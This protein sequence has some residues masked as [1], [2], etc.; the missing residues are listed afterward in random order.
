ML[1][2]LS[3]E[4]FREK[5]IDFN[6][7]LN[8]VIGDEKATNSIGKSSI[9]MVID[10]V[11]GG[12][13]LLDHNY[14]IVEELGD[15]EYLFQFEFNGQPYYFKRGTFKS[16][17]IYECNEKYE[18]EEPISIDEYRTFLKTAYSLDHIELT[19]R[20]MVSLFSRIWG[21]E[22]ID[23]KHPLHGFKRQ[24]SA[25]CID[26]FLKQYDKYKSIQ[27][28]NM[29]V[30]ELSVEKNTISKAFTQE[31][32]P[33]ITKTKYKENITKVN[34]IDAEINDIKKNLAK[35]AV[36]INEI[37][38]REV[39]EL[40]T[41][42]DSLLKEK[43]KITNRLKR[44]RLDLSQNKHIKS[45]TFS[46]LVRFFPEVDIDKI[47]EV[48]EFHSKISTILK[49]ELRESERELS[50]SLDEINSVISE[51]DSQL[52][53]VFSKIDN[54]EVIVD[55][56]HELANTHSSAAAEI[57]YFEKNDRVSD[58]LKQLK[59]KLSEE[60][61]RL[62]KII[63]D[64]VNDKTRKYVNKIYSEERRSPTLTLSQN[65]YTFTAIEDTGT[66]KAYSNLIIFDLAVL[67]TTDLPILIH[68]SVLYKNVENN[69]VAK[70]INLYI[71]LGKQSFISIDEI[72][73]YGSDAEFLLIKNRVL[74]LNNNKVLYIKDWRK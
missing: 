4:V 16:D 65:S 6:A 56:V 18:E 73:K 22:N 71:S 20:S 3:S 2:K 26:N 42:K 33:R 43:G 72:K 41:K 54:P 68:D 69:A 17:L 31:L 32:I 57:R 59:D 70:L 21:K 39:S 34:E 14:D 1:V 62:L 23:V 27:S 60:K 49:N 7:G 10:F 52:N 24:K 40:K 19:F 44:V 28:M 61:L 46:G 11:F 38:N 55:R 45:K 48:E 58:E 25:D 53:T 5:T 74:E 13:S 15:H 37:V 66:G 50:L 36:N 51:I 67:E 30:K 9:L 64:I 12:D 35:Y 47:T 29:R 63:E 8:V